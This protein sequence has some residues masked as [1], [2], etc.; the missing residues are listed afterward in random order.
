MKLNAGIATAKL[1]ESK[2]FFT[3]I[4]C[5]GVTIDIVNIFTTTRQIVIKKYKLN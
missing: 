5:F 3:N 4:L 1:K 2:T